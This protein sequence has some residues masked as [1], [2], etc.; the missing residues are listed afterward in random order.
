M[1]GRSCFCSEAFG[2]VGMASRV[3]GM[4]HGCREAR[5]GDDVRNPQ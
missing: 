3:I 5:S 1:M 2:E 4:G